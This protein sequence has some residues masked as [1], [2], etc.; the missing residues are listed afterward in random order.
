MLSGIII[1]VKLV[2]LLKAEL[3]IVVTLFGIVMLV[4]EHSR[5]ADAYISVTALPLHVAGISIAPLGLKRPLTAYVPSPSSINCK[6]PSIY[7]SPV[8]VEPL[9]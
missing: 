5:K 4:I 8:A 3:P 1:L 9:S 6:F 7:V 2:Q